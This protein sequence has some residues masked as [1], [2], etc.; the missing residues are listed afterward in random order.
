M[1]KFFTKVRTT[2]VLVLF[3][4]GSIAY[5]QEGFHKLNVGVDIALPIGNFG[6]IS[7][8]GFGVSGKVYYGIGQDMNITGSLGYLHF[9][10]K[11]QTY[12]DIW[13][14]GTQ[15]VSGPKV[16]MIPLMFG[17][18]YDFGGFYIEPKL[19]FVFANVKVDNDYGWGGSYSS[20][21]TEL[22]IGL[23]GGYRMDNLDFGAHFNIIDNLNYFGV[24]V[25]YSFDI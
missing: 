9:T 18:D 24:R 25:A 7:S 22:G 20:S 12:P 3:M 2:C 5:A 21:S 4:F 23:G 19:G 6:D 13:G 15:K 8:I 17:F 14:G 16:S 10:S 1:K 11:D